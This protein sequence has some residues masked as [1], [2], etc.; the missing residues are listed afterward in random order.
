MCS[1]LCS[2]AVAR[3]V[4]SG[5]PPSDKV[6]GALKEAMKVASEQ[7]LEIPAGLQ[8]VVTQLTGQK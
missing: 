3:S 2:K 4:A 8:A 7:T 5:Q 6:L 1:T